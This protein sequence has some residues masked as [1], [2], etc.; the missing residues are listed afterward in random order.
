MKSPILNVFLISIMFIENSFANNGS[1]KDPSNRLAKTEESPRLSE[2]EESYLQDSELN[3]DGIGES[4]NLGENKRK[5]KEN[6]KFE[7]FIKNL[8]DSLRILFASP[9][10]DT[11]RQSFLELI[12]Q[13]TDL[14]DQFA[15]LPKKNREDFLKVL[16][17]LKDS[18]IG[19]SEF[20]KE[21]ELEKNDFDYIVDI[22]RPLY[23]KIRNFAVAKN[24]PLIW[25]QL[26]KVFLRFLNNDSAP[27]P[28]NKQMAIE[29]DS[30]NSDI[31][32]FKSFLEG[33]RE[34]SKICLETPPDFKHHE[35]KFFELMLE[36]HKFLDQFSSFSKKNKKNLLK[37]LEVLK[38]NKV[39]DI[40]FL[41]D[42]HLDKDDFSYIMG[43]FQP[44]DLNI[45]SKEIRNSMSLIWN[46]F[47]KILR[48]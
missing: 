13:K 8:Q 38:Q 47:Q 4:E 10:L 23:F 29:K 19:D 14:L 22:L 2:M 26:R 16:K 30:Q 41:N 1:E 5:I 17:V 31:K 45:S 44:L 37:T 39:G 3:E 32:K 15:N 34:F 20:L 9:N 48:D 36:K 27:S 28:S 7:N 33:L 11:F 42:I 25:K 40:K 24:A 12:H 46:N 21:I 43:I 35:E 18:K 6:E